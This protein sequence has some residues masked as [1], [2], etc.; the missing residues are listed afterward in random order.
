MIQSLVAWASALQKIEHIV[1]RNTLRKHDVLLAKLR[2]S[3]AAE[4]VVRNESLHEQDLACN[5]AFA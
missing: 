2:T 4:G 3:L 5:S 1:K